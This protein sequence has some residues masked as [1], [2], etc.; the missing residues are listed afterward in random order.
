MSV[1]K[2]GRYW[3]KIAGLIGFTAVAIGAAGAHAVHDIPAQALIEKASIYQLIHAVALLA[4]RP[5]HGKAAFIAA[6][7]WTVGIILFSGGIY[8]KAFGLTQSAMLAPFGGTLLIAGWVI[9]MVGKFSDSV[10]I[11]DKSK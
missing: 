5:Y 4:L 7:C 2:S 9:I 3:I 1:L 11:N 8:F 6:Q 10:K